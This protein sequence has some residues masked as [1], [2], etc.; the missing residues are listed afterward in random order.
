[1][2]SP[3]CPHCAAPCP[4]FP[5]APKSH[6]QI[7]EDAA[8]GN[9]HLVIG[10]DFEVLPQH[11]LRAQPWEWPGMRLGAPPCPQGEG[12]APGTH[13]C[14]I[15]LGRL[16]GSEHGVA[17]R[18]L[19]EPLLEQ[20]HA[21]HVPG[22]HLAR[23]RAQVD[24]VQQ[25]G[26]CGDDGAVVSPSP[27]LQL[28]QEPRAHRAAALPWSC[29]AHPGDPAG[30]A[31][32]PAWRRSPPAPPSPGTGDRAPAPAAGGPAPPPRPRPGQR[33]HCRTMEGS[34][35][36]NCIPPLPKTSPDTE[37]TPAG[38]GGPGCPRCPHPGSTW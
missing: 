26:A 21:G 6:F 10:D 17:G 37:P 14:D 11:L 8:D 1:M 35:P 27:R 29:P 15:E 2:A 31:R 9:D 4:S 7:L 16:Q 19:R 13:T 25:D 12:D 38:V 34:L 20:G 36:A 18:Q 3:R 24:A 23:G 32:S 28:G 30:S 5:L 22:R 33:R